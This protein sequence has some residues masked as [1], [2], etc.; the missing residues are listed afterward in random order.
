MTVDSRH[1]EAFLLNFFFNQFTEF[2]PVGQAASVVKAYFSCM[3]SLIQTL[4]I[5]ANG[6]FLTN[7]T[8]VAFVSS[9]Y[10]IY[11]TSSIIFQKEIQP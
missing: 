1:G 7:V 11:F 9:I 2:L 6:K 3:S 10:F 4:K 8:N 5:L